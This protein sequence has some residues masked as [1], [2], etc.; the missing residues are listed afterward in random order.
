MQTG[1]SMAIKEKHPRVLVMALGRINA[2]DTANNGLLLRNLFG[3]WPKGQTAQIFSGSDNGDE[4]FFG[5]YYGLGPSDRRF[6]WLYYRLKAEAQ[7]PTGAASDQATVRTPL[8]SRLRKWFRATGR[9]LLFETGLFEIIFKVRLSEQMKVWLDE[10]RPQV[11]FAQGYTLGF[12]Q[13]PL[14]AATYCDVPIVYYPTDDWPT[15]TYA[16]SGALLRLFSCLSRRAIL[17][18]SRRLVENA[19]VR[20]AFNKLMQEEYRMRYGKDFA[21]LMHGDDAARFDRMPLKPATDKEGYS[22]V[23]TGYFDQHRIPLLDDIDK[24]C[25]ILKGNGLNVGVEVFPVNDLTD[26]VLCKAN[27]DH[28]HFHVCPS[29]EDLVS[30]LRSADVL[31][32]PERFGPEAGRVRFSVSSKAH[33]FMF[34]DRPILVYSAAIT[35]IAMYAK[36]ERW[37][38]VVDRQDPQCLAQA[39][40]RLLTDTKHREDVMANARRTV[41]KN[42]QLSTI[43]QSFYERLSSVLERSVSHE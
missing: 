41:I 23:C 35:G 21:V 6:G 43:Q 3:S 9:A 26:E 25:E 34:S 32:L 1:E 7:Q 27:L 40:Q 17:S 10:F 19:T 39:L 13:L 33:L 2:A 20:I 22:I 28:V 42:H 15:Y 36:E 4:G 16:H 12:T 37:A 18:E 14:L 38:E 30:V 24:A 29:H 5:R 11:I 31:I 8:Q